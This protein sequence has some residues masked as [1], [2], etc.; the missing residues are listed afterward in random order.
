VTDCA[1][2]DARAPAGNL[3]YMVRAVRLQTSSS[4]SYFNA[5][6]GVFAAVANQPAK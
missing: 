6:Q 5:S 1:Y 3:T 2:T 4:G